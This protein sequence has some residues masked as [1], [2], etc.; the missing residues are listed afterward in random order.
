MFSKKILVLLVAFTAVVL[1]LAA[2]TYLSPMRKPAGEKNFRLIAD[3][4]CYNQSKGGPELRVKSG[5][6]V[7]ITM[8]NKGEQTHEMILVDKE[9]LA[10]ALDPTVAHEGEEGLDKA[11]GRHIEPVFTGALINET[12]PGQTGS[13]TFVAGPP[14]NYVYGCFTDE[15]DTTLHAF[16]GMWGEFIV[17][18]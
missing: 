8:L 18:S 16:R 2:A 12:K 10:F 15:P 7:T 14:G 13:M 6:K 9:T 1:L 4:F 5:D 3:D 11:L 17:E